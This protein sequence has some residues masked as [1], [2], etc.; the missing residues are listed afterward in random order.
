MEIRILTQDDIKEVMP[1][2]EA[3]E[4]DKEALKMY[5]EGSANIPLRANLGMFQST[6]AR[7]YICMD[8]RLKQMP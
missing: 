6:R 3:I 5:S 8:M 7:V 4:A 2:K 1:M